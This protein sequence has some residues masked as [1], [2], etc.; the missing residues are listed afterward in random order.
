MLEVICVVVNTV[1]LIIVSVVY[2]YTLHSRIVKPRRD[3]YQGA[4][5]I[6]VTKEV[7]DAIYLI[8]LSP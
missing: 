8:T 4:H 7:G 1:T 3:H 2:N 5:W 6:Q